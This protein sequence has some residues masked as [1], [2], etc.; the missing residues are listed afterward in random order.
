MPLFQSAIFFF[1]IFSIRNFNIVDSST[2]FVAP[3]TR[4]QSTE[5]Y[6]ISI[7]FKSPL[8]STDLLLDLGG[9]F[10]WIDCNPDFYT[11]TS[12]HYIPCHTNL[13]ISLG[14]IACSNCFRPSGPGCHNNSCDLFPENPVIRNAILAQALVD[15]LALSITDGRNPGQIGMVPN[16]VLSCSD[17][18]LLLGLPEGVSGLAGLG[19]SNYSL[20]A[21][22]RSNQRSRITN[23]SSRSL[24]WSISQHK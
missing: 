4:D 21:Q 3:I 2:A 12:H 22:I 7:Y 6:T 11:S 23:S 13:C 9:K 15:S 16:F 5:L 19:R 24:V 8:E 14:S 17:D 1:I 10:S 20:P 18:S